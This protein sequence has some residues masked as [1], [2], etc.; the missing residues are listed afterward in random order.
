MTIKHVVANLGIIG[1][2]ASCSTTA[3]RVPGQQSGANAETKTALQS[4]NPDFPTLF[5]AAAGGA[6]PYPERTDRSHALLPKKRE[7]TSCRNDP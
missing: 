5:E 4:L 3:D 2:L 6:G 1:I 7:R